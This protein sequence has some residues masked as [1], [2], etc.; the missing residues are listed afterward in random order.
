M[1]HNKEQILDAIKVGIEFEIFSNDSLHGVA[2]SLKTALGKKITIPYEVSGFNKDKIP[3]KPKEKPTDTE[4]ILTKDY[5][6]GPKMMELITGPLPYAEARIQIIKMCNWIK[7]NGWT[8]EK[9]GIHLNFSLNNQKLGMKENIQAMN[10][11]RMCIEY[12]EEFIYK[13]FPNRKGNV[14]AKSI[15]QIYPSNKWMF[16][17]NNVNPSPENY[18][19]PNTK[20][21]TLNFIKV[22]EKNYIELRA[23]G[24]KNYDKKSKSI[25]EI[26][27]N[28]A[29]TLYD[30]V[31]N[32]HLTNDNIQYLTNILQK[33]KKIVRS[34]ANFNSFIINYPDIKI[35]VDLDGREQ[36][37]Q[38]FF[39]STLRDSLY[40]FIIKGKLKTG[41]INYDRD[42]GR[43]QVRDAVLTKCDDL[44]GYDFI[45]CKLEGIFYNCEF[46]NCTIENS[47][48]NDSKIIRTNIVNRC[49]VNKTTVGFGNELEECYIDSKNMNISG[50]LTKCIIRNGNI[51]ELSKQ[52][53][54]I[55]VTE[56]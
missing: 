8:S 18:L 4:Y 39:M 20:Y 25:L 21:Y 51:S 1:K 17:E 22:R 34:F 32:P 24:G 9:T 45:N 54:C 31:A 26:M 11:L 48:V 42:T 10:Q 44:T 29:L 23:L 53:D 55:T 3:V 41:F 36:V 19:S 35:S 52:K 30:V 7:E 38:T 49:K 27:E 14:Y 15:K 47:H 12:D 43:I 5:S 33:H 37:I 13:R 56:G 16:S 50:N 46:Y 40:D 2:R 6:G 28:F